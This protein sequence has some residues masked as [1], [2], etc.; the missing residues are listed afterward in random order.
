MSPI[1]RLLEFL[2]RFPPD[3]PASLLAGVIILVECA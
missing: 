3:T 1:D 2:G